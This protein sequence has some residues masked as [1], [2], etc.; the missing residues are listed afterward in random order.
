MKKVFYNET[1]HLM[2]HIR[3][4]MLRM[5]QIYEDMERPI[6]ITDVVGTPKDPTQPR[7]GGGHRHGHHNPDL[8]DLKDLINRRR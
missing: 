1:R 2:P 3:R 7:Y 4:N 5:D 8:D 6:D